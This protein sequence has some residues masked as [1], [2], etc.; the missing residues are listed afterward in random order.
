MALLEKVFNQGSNMFSIFFL[1]D[2]IGN[3]V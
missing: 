1:C 3:M 2:E